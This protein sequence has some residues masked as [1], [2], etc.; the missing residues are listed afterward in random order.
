MAASVA[1]ALPTLATGVDPPVRTEVYEGPLD[2][3]LL[4]VRREGVDIREI[5]IARICDSYLSYLDTMGEI[6]VDVAGDYLVLAATLCQ[7]K[8][9]ELLPVAAQP[10]EEEEELDPREALVRRL[11]EYERYRDAAEQLG[12]RELLDRDVYTRPMQEQPLEEQP[13]DPG[14]DAMGLMGI[15]AGVMERLGRPDPEH[16]V[17][18]ERYSLLEFSRF[19]LD[20]I[21][22]GEEGLLIELLM[23]QPTRRRRIFLFLVVL[24]LGRLGLVDVIQVFHLGAIRIRVL[25]GL[26]A[27]DLVALPEAI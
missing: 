12:N 13:L 1:V 16:H 24:E 11:L 9:R 4:L 23:E 25:R 5:P 19:I 27:Q 10:G 20:R 22:E 18:T 14:V 21:P 17:E 3:L 7:L 26:V 8:A 2:L 6:D 15:F